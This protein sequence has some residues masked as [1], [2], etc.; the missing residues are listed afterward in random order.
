MSPA[1]SA[2]AHFIRKI[3]L[4]SLVD[5]GDL[6]DVLRLF[7]PVELEAG[8]VLFS[9]GDAGKAMW[10]L[11][12]KTEVSVASTQGQSGPVVV[13]YAR[14]NDVLGEMA[15]VDEGPR[16][17]TAMVTTSGPA[18]QIDANEFHA[19]RTAM[20]PVVFKI[21]RK[22]CIDL[23]A[24]LRSTNERIVASGGP[25][26]ETTPLKLGP[27][28]APEL[29]T[30]YPSFRALPAVVRL[31]LAH[32]LEVVEVDRVTPIFAEGEKSQG[33]YFIVE[34][35]VSV[36]RNGKTLANLGP[37]TMFGV[38]ACIDSGVRSASCVTTGPALLFRMSARNFDQLF[39]AGHRFA[40]QMVDMLARQLV[41]HLREANQMLP[42]VGGKSG[43]AR[44]LAP[45]PIDSR[46]VVEPELVM[47]IDLDLEFD[48]SA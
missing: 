37:G 7:R 6:Q 20:H 29:L 39:S 45:V 24:R 42:S 36:G 22:I 19:L 18:Q 32:Q 1:Q 48:L 2:L 23:C 31:A 21:L 12:G 28:P 17:G 43:I 10:V 26:V 34:G 15:L 14:A 46:E 4:F 16:S 13:T 11:A 30:K 35:E 38:V 33:A 25:A 8:E 9:E 40:F 44:A 27:R 41:S 47:S 3:P 5:E